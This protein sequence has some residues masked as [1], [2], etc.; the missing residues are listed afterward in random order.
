MIKDILE[1]YWGYTSFRPLQ[2]EIINEVLEHRDLLALMPT[3]GGKSITYQVPALAM[4]GL[5]LVVSPLIA[6]IK[7][8]VEDLRAR[9]IEAEY[10]VSGLD[11]REIDRILDKCIYSSCKFL[12]VSP[13]R[14]KVATYSVQI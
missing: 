7:D 6:L 2:E 13:E 4:E 10:I 14:L 8:Q 5:C 9:G 1:K 11:Y 3:G 12:Y